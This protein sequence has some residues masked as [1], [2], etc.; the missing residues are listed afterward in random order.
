MGLSMLR[1]IAQKVTSKGKGLLANVQHLLPGQGKGFISLKLAA[2]I[3]ENKNFLNNEG[4]S[5]INLASKI[6]NKDLTKSNDYVMFMV[7]GGCL[8]EF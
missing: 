2:D 6:D 3:I 1:G 5:H 8:N 4:I 7:D